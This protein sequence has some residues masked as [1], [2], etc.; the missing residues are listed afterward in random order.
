MGKDGALTE[1]SQASARRSATPTGVLSPRSVATDRTPRKGGHN[2]SFRLGSLSDAAATP[3]PDE[4]ELDYWGKLWRAAGYV[5][6]RNGDYVKAPGGVLGAKPT[7]ESIRAM[8][9]TELAEQERWLAED[10]PT[11][12]RAVRQDAGDSR[13]ADDNEK[14]MEY[15]KIAELDKARELVQATAHRE[16]QKER[17]PVVLNGRDRFGWTALHWLAEGN[18]EESPKTIERK[19]EMIKVLMEHKSVLNLLSKTNKGNTALVHAIWNGNVRVCQLLLKKEPRLATELTQ[20]G[21]TA[22]H[23]A[24]KGQKMRNKTQKAAPNI[25]QLLLRRQHGVD[26]NLLTHGGDTALHI[27]CSHG[28]TDVARMLLTAGASPDIANLERRTPLHIAAAED[29]AQMME[30]L[31]SFNARLDLEDEEGRTAAALYAIKIVH[32]LRL[33]RE[34]SEWQQFDAWEKKEAEVRMGAWLAERG[35][36]NK[37]L[38]PS[39]EPVTVLHHES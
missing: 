18:L 28:F 12:H 19:L 13:A 30:L 7:E 4:S 26:V 10:T 3:I 27:A 8:V 29:D 2:S 22:L 33:T 34:G 6:A 21:W 11:S 23:W 15:A 20:G 36:P 5:P 25:V 32:T 16:D 31:A 9:D 39:V 35:L 24:V 1:R 37:L 14:L 38:S 17:L